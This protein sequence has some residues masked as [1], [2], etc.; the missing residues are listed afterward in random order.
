MSDEDVSEVAKL[1]AELTEYKARMD[2]AARGAVDES[3]HYCPDCGWRAKNADD[4]CPQHP[5]T[6]M[7]HGGIDPL[8]GGKKLLRVG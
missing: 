4:A 6:P 3:D 2:A 5:R 7:N 1:R 8:T